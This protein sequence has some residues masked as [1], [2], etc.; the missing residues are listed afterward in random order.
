MVFCSS[1]N[2]LPLALKLLEMAK[3]FVF[4]TD[5]NKQGMR[6]AH[7]NIRGITSKIDEV[8]SILLE[9][10]IDI[11]CLSETFLDLTKPS[12]FFKIN[13][14]DILRKDRVTGQ[15]GGLLCFIRKGIPFQMIN[16]LDPVIPE[17]MTLKITQTN[18]LL[19]LFV[20]Y[21]VLPALLLIGIRFFHN[22]FS[23]AQHCVVRS[24]F[25]VIS[26]WI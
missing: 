15:G 17:S 9:Y 5:G 22:M 25:W 2:I 1:L 11:F 16:S 26:M 20:C 18:T 14:Y 4:Q 21:T 12:T 13:N 10:K 8:K 6:I 23:N 19:L 24:S 7:L 3:N